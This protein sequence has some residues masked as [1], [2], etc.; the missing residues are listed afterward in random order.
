RD[1][2]DIVASVV[3][4]SRVEFADGASPDVRNYNVSCDKI[5]EVLGFD[6]Q[7]TVRRGVEQLYAAY[8]ELPLTEELFLGSRFLRIRHVREGIRTGSITPDLRVAQAATGGQ[9]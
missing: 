5:R 2:A 8:K 3:P 4:G 6:T 1:V 7:W 9:E